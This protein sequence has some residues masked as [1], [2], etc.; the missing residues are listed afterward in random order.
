MDPRPDHR[1]KSYTGSER[2]AGRKALIT[3]GDSGMGRAASIAMPAKVP[4]LQSIIFLTNNR[5]LMKSSL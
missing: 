1:E 3:G 2:L 4:T 5:T